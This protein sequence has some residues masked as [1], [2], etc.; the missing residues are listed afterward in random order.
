[1]A[2]IGVSFEQSNG[3]IDIRVHEDKRPILDLSVAEH[4]WSDVNHLYQAFMR[5][6]SGAY[7]VN[8]H[9]EGRFTEHEEETGHLKLYD[10]PMC[11]GL[12]PGEIE[13]YPFRELWMQN[14]V[15]TFEELETLS[16]V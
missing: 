3:K 9:M 4:G 13:T 16:L 1:M 7:K 12:R 2:D 11:E 6:A 5:D 10:H 15:Q 8:I 14:G